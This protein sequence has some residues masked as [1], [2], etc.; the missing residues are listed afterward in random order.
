[1]RN[2]QK[3]IVIS[4]CLLIFSVILFRRDTSS[5]IFVKSNWLVWLLSAQHQVGF[6]GELAVENGCIVISQ[7]DSGGSTLPVWP[8]NL[9]LEESSDGRV[10]IT[11]WG[12]KLFKVGDT[13]TVGGGGISS[14]SSYARRLIFLNQVPETCP[15][16]RLFLVGE[17]NL[18][19]GED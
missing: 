1:M 15:F 14:N 5:I 7:N 8:S 18:M 12:R 9:H 17:W 4:L 19:V 13:I 10:T 2:V 11:R 3:I 16:E 6:T